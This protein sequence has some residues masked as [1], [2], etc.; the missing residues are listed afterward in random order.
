MRI[1]GS[2]LPGS[3]SFTRRRTAAGA[4]ARCRRAPLAPSWVASASTG[5]PWDEAFARPART[6][7]R[8]GGSGAAPAAP[9]LAICPWTPPRQHR[10]ASRPSRALAAAPLCA[11]QCQPLEANLI[12]VDAVRLGYRRQVIDHD[13]SI[14]AA[15]DLDREPGVPIAEFEQD[16]RVTQGVPPHADRF[17]PRLRRPDRSSHDPSSPCRKVH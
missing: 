4:V 14:R 1:A 9:A 13:P 12:S 10:R 2:S 3:S 8:T 17:P 7:R 16:Q 5:R 15:N 11:P 6:D